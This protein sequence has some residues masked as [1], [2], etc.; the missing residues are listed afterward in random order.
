MTVIPE[1]VARAIEQHALS[2]PRQEVCGLI[3]ANDGILRVHQLRN[4]HDTPETHYSADLREALAVLGDEVL[5]GVYHSH[6]DMAP[7]PSPT[8]IAMWTNGDLLM[9]I[10]SVLAEELCCYRILDGEVVEA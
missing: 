8:D 6:V 2:K 1:P 10:Y 7:Y 4:I 5:V 3:T 9:A